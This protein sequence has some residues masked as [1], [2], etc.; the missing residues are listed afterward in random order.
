MY[1]ATVYFGKQHQKKALKISMVKENISQEFKL[2]N[3]GETRDYFFKEIKH[4][5]LMRKKHKK[6][7]TALSYIKYLFILTS[8]VTGCVLIPAFSSLA[9]ILVDTLQKD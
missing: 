4:N 5:E 9:G 3:I 1:F 8:Q 6:V 7:C 2:K